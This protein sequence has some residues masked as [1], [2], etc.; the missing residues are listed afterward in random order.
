MVGILTLIFGLWLLHR[1]H[2]DLGAN[3]SNTLEVRERH[4]LITHGVYRR[5]RHPMYA[6]LLAHGLGQALLVPNWIAGPSFLLPFAILF[7]VRVG[8]EERMMRDEFGRGYQEYITRTDRLL[9]GLW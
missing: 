2:A 7:G 1:S 6:A 3:W 9:P 5:I 4:A 8:S